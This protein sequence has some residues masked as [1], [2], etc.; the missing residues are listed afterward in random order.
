MGFLAKIKRYARAIEFRADLLAE[1]QRAKRLGVD[2]PAWLRQQ[3]L[4]NPHKS[5]DLINFLRFIQPRDKVR[6]IDVGANTGFWAA[7]FLRLFQNTSATMIEPVPATAQ[8]LQQRFQGDDRVIVINA[9]AS[10][11]AGPLDMTV[12]ESTLASVHAYTDAST[13][14]VAAGSRIQVKTIKLD[15]LRFPEDDRINVLKVD[16]Q[17]HEV[18]ALSSGPVF[19]KRI[20]VALIEV[21][22]AHEFV[23]LQPSFVECAALLKQADLYPAIFQDYGMG[24]GP[25]ATARDVLFVRSRLVDNILGD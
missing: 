3:V 9:A 1:L 5:E 11:L 16:V 12:G 6:L 10:S 23:G 24:L 18:S 15:D 14:A 13:S 20:S 25:Y 22:F 4:R 2:V 17:G 8:R 7:D 19:L 21:S